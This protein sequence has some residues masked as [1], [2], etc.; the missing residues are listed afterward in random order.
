MGLPWVRLDATFPHND[1][2][3]QLIECGQWRAVSVYVFGLAYC[4]HQETDGHI[5]KRALRVIHAR[6]VDAATLTAVGLWTTNGDGGWVVHDW[7]EYQQLAA[8]SE[9]KRAAMRHAACI[10]WHSQPC[11]NCT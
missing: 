7:A 5:P 9:A 11:P 8:T 10:R 6:P 2:I 4:G 3:L 1:K